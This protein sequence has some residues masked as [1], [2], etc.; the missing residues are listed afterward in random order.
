M[1]NKLHCVR[2]CCSNETFAV[3]ERFENHDRQRRAALM[4]RDVVAIMKLAP[5][6]LSW[7]YLRKQ[8]TNLRRVLFEL[9][10]VAISVQAD[11]ELLK[12]NHSA[13][14]EE[15]SA[16]NFCAPCWLLLMFGSKMSASSCTAHCK[17][18]L[19]A[20]QR[21]IS[22]AVGDL[23]ASVGNKKFKCPHTAIREQDLKGSNLLHSFTQ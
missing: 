7:R 20:F 10:G 12:E 19:L 2:S 14:A 16:T 23:P 22:I 21:E 1:P 6:I 11:Q 18:T 5:A 15:S 4:A 17:V 13:S 9:L 3:V 8:A